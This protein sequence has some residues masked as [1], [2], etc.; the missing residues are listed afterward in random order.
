VLDHEELALD[1]LRFQIAMIDPR[2]KAV[3]LKM[4]GPWYQLSGYTNVPA[5]NKYEMQSG[6][7]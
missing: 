6:K 7:Q 2:V 3:A 4:A 1:P 5:W